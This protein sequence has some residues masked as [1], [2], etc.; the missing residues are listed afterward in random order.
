MLILGNT[1]SVRLSLSLQT[2]AT[3]EKL[4]LED[5]QRRV[6]RELKESDK[7][8]IPKYFERDLTVP[9]EHAWIYKYRE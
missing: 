9:Y 1:I 4:V 6:H 8:W 5:E 7:E 3:R 2:A